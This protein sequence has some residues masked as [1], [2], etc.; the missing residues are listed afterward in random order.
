MWN[1]SQKTKVAT[2]KK[3]L[4]LEHQ[5]FHLEEKT[6][7]CYILLGVLL[8]P[9]PIFLT[10]LFFFCLLITLQLCILPRRITLWSNISITYVLGLFLLPKN[11]NFLVIFN[12]K[13][14]IVCP[15]QIHFSMFCETVLEI[16]F[17]LFYFYRSTSVWLWV[18][19]N[20]CLNMLFK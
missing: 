9:I 17:Q 11:L 16:F 5:F 20:T 2:H 6:W 3:N 4:K 13:T 10:W 12:L 8:L 7:P 19:L 18:G 1:K 14:Y 15:F